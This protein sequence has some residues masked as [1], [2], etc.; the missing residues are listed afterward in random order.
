VI[1]IVDAEQMVVDLVAHAMQVL[2]LV[3]TQ[4]LLI[5]HA[6]MKVKVI[7]SV[8]S[9]NALFLFILLS[10]NVLEFGMELNGC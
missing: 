10:Q 2:F 1:V 9:R 8:L 5:L 3:V 4:V 6:P 7:Q